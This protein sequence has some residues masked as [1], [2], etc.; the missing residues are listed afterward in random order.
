MILLPKIPR[1][2]RPTLRPVGEASILGP[3]IAP[4]GGWHHTILDGKPVAVAYCP[5]C[6]KEGYL[7]DHSIADDGTVTPSLICS[8]APCDFHDTVKLAAWEA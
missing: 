2:A 7:D 1:P 5:K 8:H 6:G 3:A 4:Q